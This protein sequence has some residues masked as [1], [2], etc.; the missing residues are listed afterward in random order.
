MRSLSAGEIEEVLASE[1]LGCL[2]C[3]ADNKPYVIPMAFAYKN[4]V[5]YGQTN[6]GKKTD[7]LRKN[8][9]V[10]F[11]VTQMKGASWRSVI[12]EGTFQEFDFTNPFAPDV[13]AAI[14][15]LHERLKAVQ[16]IIGVSVP[17]MTDGKPRPLTVDGKKATLFRIV[18]D[19]ISGR[20]G[21]SGS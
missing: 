7:A 5:L 9:A 11:Q 1:T 17:I 10:C 21:G 19:T 8:P 3:C 14:V 15:H 20:G 4:G 2:A 18:V 16:D 12:M 6:E 13:A